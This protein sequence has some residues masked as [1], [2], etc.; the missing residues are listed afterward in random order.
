MRAINGTTMLLH[1]YSREDINHV[2]ID[3]ANSHMRQT[4]HRGKTIKDGY[5]NKNGYAT[6]VIGTTPIKKEAD[7]REDT[8]QTYIYNKKNEAIKKSQLHQYDVNK[9][10]GDT[11][12]TT[13]QWAMGEETSIFRVGAININGISKS[14]DWI[15]WEVLLRHMTTLQI[16]ALGLTEPNINFKNKDILNRL[17]EK[18]KLHDRHMQLSTSCS[19]Q[20]R[21]SIK[22]MGGTMMVLDGKWA[23]RKDSTFSDKKGRWSAITLTGKRNKKVTFLTAYRV[24]AQKGGLGSTIYHQ[25]QIDFEEEGQTN[26]DLRK[27][28]CTDLTVTIRELHRQNHIV[29]LMGDFN[30]DL[31]LTG[32]QINTMLRDCGLAN[33]IHQAHGETVKLPPTYHRGS[34]C[35][36][37]IAITDNDRVPK[38]CVRRAGY[39]PFYHYFCTDHRL[40]FCDI[41]LKMLFGRI[42]PEFHR[43]LRRPFTTKNVEKCEKFKEKV[44]EMYEKSNIFNIVEHL[45][46]RFQRATPETIADIISDCI[47]YGSVASQLLLGA[48]RKIGNHAYA[49]GKPYSDRLSTVAKTFH[50][51]RNELRFLKAKENSS[52]SKQQ[53][54]DLISDIKQAYQDLR[55]TQKEATMI[56]EEFLKKLAAKRAGEWNL[57]TN[58]ALNT[59]IRAEASRRTFARHSKVMKGGT[60][61]S[62][63][64]LV[65]AAPRYAESVAGTE[66]AGWCNITDEETIF[67]LLLRR[68]TQQFMRSSNCP[69]AHG[70]IV[71][72][73]GIDCDKLSTTL[74]KMRM[75]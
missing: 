63:N 35:L 26:V 41:D 74:Q 37:L 46:K 62:I 61:G 6:H 12:Q 3:E 45:D 24:C 1:E 19:N 69:F 17:Y 66:K 32:G 67:A 9:G 13:D 29:I 47:K 27:R 58:A 40:I 16:D 2:Q 15:E 55:S 8:I 50:D 36:D 10:Y 60:K 23:G 56:R 43:F 57:S 71:D 28:F 42:Q 5:N 31:N 52:L 51:K 22:K 30:D 14:L 44:R 4:S 68:N 34:K 21:T 70:N 7:T 65:V 75:C 64:E 73:C 20:L 38:E 39:L 54:T 72:A 33:V 25:Q 59:I 11:L 53:E 49:N 48:G 18:M